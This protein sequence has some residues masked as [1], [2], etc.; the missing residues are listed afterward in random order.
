[1]AII[2]LG[3]EPGGSL[4]VMPDA[5]TLAHR[6]PTILAAAQNNVPAEFC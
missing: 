3:R 6:A 2:A 5:F 1:M 4:L